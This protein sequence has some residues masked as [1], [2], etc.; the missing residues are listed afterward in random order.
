MWHACL[1][2]LQMSVRH[3]LWPDT[4]R[5]ALMDKNPCPRMLPLEEAS[6][7]SEGS[8]SVASF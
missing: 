1:F 3:L 2:F 6:S 8:L 5:H 7:D 4:E